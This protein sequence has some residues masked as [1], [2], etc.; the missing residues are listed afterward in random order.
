MQ[1]VCPACDTGQ[2]QLNECAGRGSPSS[3]SAW[4]TA[5]LWQLLPP[6]QPL[7]ISGPSLSSWGCPH[8][9]PSAP[10]PT[11]FLL[12]TPRTEFTPQ[13]PCPW[14]SWVLF[15]SH[16]EI[17]VTLCFINPTG[18]TG[19]RAGREGRAAGEAETPGRL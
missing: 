10:T 17:Y 9:P 12:H 1:T 8:L 4:G 19:P 11:P 7:A 16:R 5:V 13:A 18:I 2:L 6:H 3:R 15:S 14:A